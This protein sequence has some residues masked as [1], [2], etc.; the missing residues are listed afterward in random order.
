[1]NLSFL[2]KNFKFIS[3]LQDEVFVLELDFLSKFCLH[4]LLSLAINVFDL[5]FVRCKVPPSGA[6][7][8]VDPNVVGLLEKKPIKQRS[9]ESGQSDG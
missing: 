3:F 9:P 2:E 1:M 7:G 5:A 6:G 4:L 8:K